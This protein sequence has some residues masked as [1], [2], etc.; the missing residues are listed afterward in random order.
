MTDNLQPNRSRSRRWLHLPM[1]C[2]AGLILC[3]YAYGRMAPNKAGQETELREDRNAGALSFSQRL[4]LVSEKLTRFSSLKP[5][6]LSLEIHNDPKGFAGLLAL[7]CFTLGIILADLLGVALLVVFLV[8]AAKRR[9]VLGLTPAVEVGWTVWDAVVVFSFAIVLIALLSLLIPANPYKTVMVAFL[10]YP[11]ACLYAWR[12]AKARA[13]APRQAVGIRTDAIGRDLARGLLTYL[14]A[15]PL[16]TVAALANLAIARRLFGPSATGRTPLD[17]LFQSDS[18]ALLILFGVLAV[19]LAPVAEEFL[20]RGILYGALR[21]RVGAAWAISLSAALFAGVH[22]SFFHFLP[23]FIIGLV[24][25]YAYER[26]RSLVTTICIHLIQN[27]V[28]VS[29]V[30]LLK[31]AV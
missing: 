3:L 24:L 1:V 10:S 15:M 26:T 27:T 20:F 22:F 13:A 16:I 19:F 6:D 7:G 9:P 14:S 18:T 5:D 31:I 23:L 30:L 21:R 12:T 29:F 28:A 11:L 25:G 17:V 2:A 8:Q 4:D